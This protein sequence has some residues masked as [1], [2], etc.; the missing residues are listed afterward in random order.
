MEL[1]PR[2]NSFTLSAFRD[3]DERFVVGEANKGE[4]AHDEMGRTLSSSTTTTGDTFVMVFIC[5]EENVL[6]C[7]V[8]YY[9]SSVVRQ[10]FFL[11]HTLHYDTLSL[12]LSVSQNQ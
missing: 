7:F 3:V 2:R 12:S 11:W 5:L 10:S 1:I 6:F 9:N 4:N 8:M